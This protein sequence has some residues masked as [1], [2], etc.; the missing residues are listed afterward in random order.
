[1]RQPAAGTRDDKVAEALQKSLFEGAVTCKKI[2]S[3]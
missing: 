3:R 2:F 1:V